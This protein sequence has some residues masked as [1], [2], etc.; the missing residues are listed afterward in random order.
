MAPFPPLLRP[1]GAA[2]LRG[3]NRGVQYR[4]PGGETGVATQKL[5]PPKKLPQLLNAHLLPQVS[6]ASVLFIKT[7]VIV[8]CCSPCAMLMFMLMLLLPVRVRVRVH[9]H[10]HVHDH[11]HVQ[12]HVHVHAHVH[13]AC[14][15]SC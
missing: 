14:S 11:V 6:L 2:P 3:R 5:R 7:R 1:F 15:C 12:V 8:H 9:V 13:V 4:P 10:V